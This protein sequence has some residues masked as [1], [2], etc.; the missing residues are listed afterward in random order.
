[1][2]D[3]LILPVMD[4]G[5]G[6]PGFRQTQRVSEAAILRF[7]ESLDEVR[8]GRKPSQ[9]WLWENQTRSDFPLLMADSIDRSMLAGYAEYQPTYP[10]YTRMTTVPDFRPAKRFA[11]DGA[12]GILPIINELGPYPQVSIDETKY[13]V[14]LQKRGQRMGFSFESMVND[15]LGAFRDTPMRFGRAARRTREYVATYAYANPTNQGVFFTDAH[16]NK[17]NIANGSSNANPPLGLTGLLDAYTVL[18]RQVDADGQPIS[19]KGA[20]V[21]Y[22]TNLE[23]T[24][25]QLRSMINYQTDLRGGTAGTAGSSQVM[26]NVQNILGDLIWA[27]NSQLRLVD[28]VFGATG[29]YLFCNP[30]EGRPALIVAELRGRQQP[31]LWQRMPDAMRVGGG[32]TSPMDGS[33]DNDSA[34]EF[35]IRDFFGA[36]QIDPKCAVFSEGDGT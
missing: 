29:W 13:E 26:L 22:P 24:V 20:V 34:Q 8:R 12:E 15:D 11:M 27:P 32:S 2:R 23:A 28:T 19:L 31:E 3:N 36:V 25:R 14:T 18:S 7:E 33:F 21:V 4:G 16:G 35:K 9:V 10:L 17:V 1:M 5:V 6:E 30:N